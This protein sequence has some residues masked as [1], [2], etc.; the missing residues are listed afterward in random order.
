[1]RR[2]NKF[3]YTHLYHS[4]RLYNIHVNWE[5]IKL[6]FHGTDTDTDTDTDFLADFRAILT[7]KSARL[8]VPWNLHFTAAT[9]YRRGHGD[10]LSV[11]HGGV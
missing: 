4:R 3:V 2:W 6:K 9:G 11:Q 1:M 8:S 7:R 10:E 5:C